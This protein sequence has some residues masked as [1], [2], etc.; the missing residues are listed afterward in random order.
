MNQPHSLRSLGLFIFRGIRFSWYTI[1][2]KVYTPNPNVLYTY[3][4]LTEGVAPYKT[5]VVIV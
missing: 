3:R 1:E 4:G 5:R 2:V